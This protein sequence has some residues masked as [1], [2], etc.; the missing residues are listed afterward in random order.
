MP[1]RP[2]III[3]K[4][5]IVLSENW[6]HELHRNCEYNL[7]HYFFCEILTLIHSVGPCWPPTLNLKKIFVM[8]VVQ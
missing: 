3:N 1:I 6:I 8:L 4:S 7:F 5:G 2:F